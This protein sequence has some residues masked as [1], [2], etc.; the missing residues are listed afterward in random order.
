MT[1]AE[2]EH[3]KRLETLLRASFDMLTKIDPDSVQEVVFYDETDCDVFCLRDDIAT[4]LD[5]EVSEP[6]LFG[7]WTVRADHPHL[8][9][10]DK[11]F[12]THAETSDY[13]EELGTMGFEN[14]RSEPPI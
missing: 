13:M 8:G 6:P 1:P 9:R 5:F 7:E 2:K 12:H 11:T 10:P 3:L 14:I 4:E